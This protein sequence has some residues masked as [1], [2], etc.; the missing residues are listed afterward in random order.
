MATMIERDL[1]L[2]APPP[3]AS[4]AGR[5]PPVKAWALV[6]LAFLTLYGY[7]VAKWLT[8]PHTQ[9]V[10]AGPSEVPGWMKTAYDI[11]LPLGIVAMVGVLYW[12][13]VRP[14]IRERR[15]TT[16]GLMVIVFVIS[17]IQ[18][19]WL[20]YYVPVATYN[21]HLWN[22]GSWV[23]DVPGWQ[24]YGTAGHQMTEPLLF[25]VPMY[26][27][28]LLPLALLGT[29]IMRRAKARCPNIGTLGLLAV[30]FAALGTIGMV[31]EIAFLQLGFYGYRSAT[32]ELTL[33]H[34]HFYQ[35]PVYEM[36][37]LGAWLTSFSALLYFK[38]DKG[39]TL[40]ERGVDQLRA[41]AA[42]KVALRFLALTGAMSVIF[43]V[44]YNVPWQFFALKNEAWPA[45]VQ[46]RSYLTSGMC[47]PGTDRACPGPDLPIALQDS[48]HFDPQ[49]RIVV[50]SG[51]AAPGSETIDRATGER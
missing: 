31:L 9:R 7:I 36:P 34:G 29:W 51:V 28:A 30:C 45:D 13:I 21:T 20:N 47:G 25:S 46:N 38:N 33:F 39:Q 50:P 18:D 49:G 12:F 8:G 35:Y 10:D 4:A 5:K 42:Q 23:N 16:N 32:P 19:P 43:L 24:S 15:V 17:V 37:F 26:V 22:A 40:V 41:S 14:W 6:G 3:M 2:P 44:T 1:R 27:Y 48:A 11:Y